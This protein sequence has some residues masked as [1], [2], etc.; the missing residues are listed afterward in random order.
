M[1]DTL[2]SIYL[3]TSIGGTELDDGEH[4]ILTTNATTRY[5]IK[6][7]YVNGTSNLTN[8][9]LELNGFNVGSISSNATGSLIIPP[10][11]TLKIKTTDYPY[12]FYKNTTWA[13][14]G[15]TLYYTET[16]EDSAGNASSTTWDTYHTG[17]SDYSDM[18]DL[19]RI[20]RT[21]GDEYLY[22]TTNDDNSVQKFYSINDSSGAKSQRAYYNYS[23][24]MITN[25]KVYTFNNNSSLEFSDQTV[26][27]SWQN[28]AYNSTNLPD[29]AN[30]AYPSTHGN[31]YTP[32]PTSSYPRGQGA[33]GFIWYVPQSG[34]TQ[35]LYAVNVT[36]GSFHTFSV[37]PQNWTM[38]SNK[39]NFVP[40]VDYENDVLY[41]Y[42]AYSNQTQTVQAKFDNW[43]SI[44]ALDNANNP[45]QHTPSNVVLENKHTTSAG[46]HYTTGSMSRAVMGYD[47]KGGFT[48]MNTSQNLVSVAK[49]FNIN[50]T[51]TEI[52]ADGNT[53]TSPNYGFVRKQTVISNSEASALSLSAPT[54]GVQLLGIKS[55]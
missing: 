34:Y 5:V 7:M 29:L 44:V 14:N 13:L 28:Y 48:Y 54:F 55:V 51:T 16:Y 35:D 46:A 45:N 6:D 15:Q 21:N 11:S 8:T 49:D 22:Y 27:V 30:Y 19:V 24:F 52:T 32:Y 3:N 18:I 47:A 37:S 4:T 23:P 42:A 50:S 33:H 53:I 2:E 36:N 20:T 26:S 10:N 25:N 12:Q 38:S 17:L 39:G 43:S 9:Y 1:A 31:S 41:I 40:S